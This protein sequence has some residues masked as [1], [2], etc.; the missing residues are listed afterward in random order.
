MWDWWGWQPYADYGARYDLGLLEVHPT[1]LERFH[2]HRHREPT[3]GWVGSVLHRPDMCRLPDRIE[4]FWQD[5]W[6]RIGMALG[7]VGVSGR[8]QY[9]RGTLAALWAIERS[10]PGGTVLLVG[11]DNVYLGRTLDIP[12]GFCP[13]YR[14]LPTTFSFRGYRGGETKQ[15]NHDFAVERRVIELVARQCGVSAVFSQ[16]HL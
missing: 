11:F 2:R 9:T 4:L 7:G 8:L 3:I 1:L 6:V 16:D 13:A 10:A 14:A 12:D 5:P 15:G